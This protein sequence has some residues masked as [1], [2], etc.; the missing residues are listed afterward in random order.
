MTSLEIRLFVWSGIE[1]W[2]GGRHMGSRGLDLLPLCGGEIA[3][4]LLWRAQLNGT[5]SAINMA[6]W[7]NVENSS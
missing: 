5:S 1:P 3:V 7:W 2:T 6:S 4:T